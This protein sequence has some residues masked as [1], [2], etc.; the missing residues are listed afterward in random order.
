VVPEAGF[1]TASVGSQYRSSTKGVGRTMAI[2]FRRV[3]TAGLVAGLMISLSALAMVPVVGDQMD[4]VL[5]ARG[6]PPLSAGAMVYF[7]AQSFVTG[8]MLVWL[9]AA[10]QPRFRPGPRTALIVAGFMWLVGGCAANLANV[11]YG[12]MPVSL[13][14]VGTLWALVELVVACQVGAYL[15]QDS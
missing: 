15:Y 11:A 14:V 2:N 10:V 4:A 9:Y 5:E 1:E 6:V 3:L 7:V 8:V 12:F 13:T